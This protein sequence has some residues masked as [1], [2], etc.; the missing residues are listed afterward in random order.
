MQIYLRE[1][2]KLGL[3]DCCPY[4]RCEIRPTIAVSIVGTFSLGRAKYTSGILRSI[5]LKVFQYWI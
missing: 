2:L 3:D 1:M 5:L 4:C